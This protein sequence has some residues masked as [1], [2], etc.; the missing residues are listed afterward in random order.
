MQ[1]NIRVI[2]KLITSSYSVYILFLRTN[3]INN[4]LPESHAKETEREYKL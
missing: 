2:F 4:N 1:L 3:S